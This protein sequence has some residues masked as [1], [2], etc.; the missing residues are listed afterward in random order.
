MV[1]RKWLRQICLHKQWNQ[2]IRTFVKRTDLDRGFLLISRLEYKLRIL[3]HPIYLERARD[4]HCEQLGVTY[5]QVTDGHPNIF[6]IC[7]IEC[8][9]ISCFRLSN[10]FSLRREMRVKRNFHRIW[11]ATEKSLVKRSLVPFRQPFRRPLIMCQTNHAHISALCCVF[12]PFITNTPY[13]NH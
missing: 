1:Y 4:D 5:I 7:L 8:F 2:M 3:C 11:N 9:H 10:W 12:S 13:P 6:G